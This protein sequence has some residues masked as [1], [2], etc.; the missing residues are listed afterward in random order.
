MKVWSMEAFGEDWGV[1]Q[2]W[3]GHDFFFSVLP[4]LL[5]W[6]IYWEMDG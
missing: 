5:F 6:R 3:V 2:F 1:S 4:T